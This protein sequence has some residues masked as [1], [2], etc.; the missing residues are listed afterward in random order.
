MVNRQAVLAVV[1]E[2]TCIKLDKLRDRMAMLEEIRKRRAGKPREAKQLS[3]LALRILSKAIHV[4]S[5]TADGPPMA[6]AQKKGQMI[7]VTGRPKGECV[8]LTL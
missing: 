4:R 5:K 2:G 7:R 1:N 6:P 8:L 3:N